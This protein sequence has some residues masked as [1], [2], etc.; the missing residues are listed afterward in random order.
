MRDEMTSRSLKQS[1]FELFL[2]RLNPALREHQLAF[3]KVVAAAGPESIDELAD[4]VHRVSCP[5]GLKQLTLEFSYYFPWPEWVPVIDRLLLHEQDLDLFETGARALGRMR[6]PEALAALRALSLSRATP[7]FREVVDQVLHESDPAEAFQHHFS[8]LLQGS[9]KPGEANEGAHQLAKL[10]T[11][12]SLESLKTAVSHPDPLIFRHSLRLI[13]QIPSKE[14]AAFLLG[15]M[16]DA[17]QDALE[18]REARIFLTGARNLPRPEVL[19]KA[20]QALSVRWKEGQPE[21]VA[22]LTSGQVD[23]IQAAVTVLREPGTGILDTFLLE[24]VLAAID[25]KP[26]HL[27]KHLSQMGE[28]AQQRARR[29]DFALDTTAQGLAAMA[30]QGHI[31]PESLLVVLAEP[32]RQNSGN[33]GVATALARLVPPG[34]QDLLDLLL[35]QPEGALRSAALEIL[36]ERKDEAFRPALLK[37]RRDAITDIADR[38]L[39]HL[40]QL[41]NPESTARAF[42]SD[43][44][45]QEVLLGLRF[46]SMHRLEALVPDLLDLT[47]KE[48][49]DAILIAAFD[50]L[51]G[52][53]SSRAV[54]PLLAILHSGQ[55]PRIQIAIAEAL[56]ELGDPDG[57][58]RLS[59]KARELNTPALHTLAVEALA[60]AYAGPDQSLPSTA[61]DTLL[62]A[63]RGGWSDRNP[64]P[65]RR[66]IADALSAIQVQDPGVW[67]KLSD[68]VQATLGEKRQ[69]GA[70]PAEDLAHLQSCGRALAQKALS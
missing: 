39:W 20:I 18:D 49:R 8:R 13:G 66:R 68:L 23:R 55:G 60:H 30:S 65:F 24:T 10:L 43:P 44:D 51:G 50:T 54:E 28:A 47:A 25:E 37:L 70:V 3:F 21:A 53:G 29:I 16:N 34:A 41:A 31:G 58:L 57:A 22:D 27:A 56:R 45:P 64:W 15:Y 67:A 12:D 17:Q 2:D 36:G 59:A 9:G 38:S 19:E 48:T 69:P 46:I 5:V 40:G 4:R 52:I 7:G 63:V 26:A 14:A 11:H 61:S 35:D 62:E 1:P 32:L 42:L 6:T 33:A